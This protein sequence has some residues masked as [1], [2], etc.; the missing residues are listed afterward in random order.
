MPN[1]IMTVTIP[2]PPGRKDLR[3]ISADL[4]ARIGALEEVME[5]EKQRFDR[6]QEKLIADHKKRMDSF[7][8]ALGNYRNMLHMEEAFAAL[9]KEDQNKVGPMPKDVKMPMPV[10]KMSLAEFFIDQLKE[11]GPMAKDELRRAAMEAGYF[12]PGDSGGRATHV[13]LVNI[14]RNN[15]VINDGEKFSVVQTEDSLL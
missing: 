11:N 5:I 6:E 12:E 9:G 3:D 4:R 10:A 13:T 14:S 8:G 1:D 7:K 15:R 2:R